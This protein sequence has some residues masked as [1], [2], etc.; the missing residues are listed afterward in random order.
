M[1]S[2]RKIALAVAA[3]GL[4][5]AGIAVAE[6]AKPSDQP[7]AERHEHGRQRMNELHGQM[8]GKHA[9]MGERHDGTGG[10]HG[11]MGMQS[12]AMG[13]RHGQMGESGCAGTLG[14]R[15][16]RHNS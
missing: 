12:G 7:R 2:I 13:E 14:D 11:H 9:Q 15:G 10:R 16:H 4:L 1:T 3:G 8:G 5:G 6:E